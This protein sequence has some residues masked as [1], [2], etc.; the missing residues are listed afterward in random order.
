MHYT[1]ML[2]PEAL[3][4]YIVAKGKRLVLDCLLRIVENGLLC[5]W[6]YVSVTAHFLHVPNRQS[7]LH[8]VLRM[9]SWSILEETSN[10][11]RVSRFRCTAAYLTRS[12]L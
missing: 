6:S 3:L 11:S 9:N 2:A 8:F 7:L 10:I 1:T 5:S 4:T 12:D